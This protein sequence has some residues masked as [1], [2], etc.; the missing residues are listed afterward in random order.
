MKTGGIMA[1]GSTLQLGVAAGNFFLP[2]INVPAEN[3]ILCVL[4]VYF[5]MRILMD[6]SNNGCDHQWIVALVDCI[7]RE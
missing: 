4:V 3:I 1:Q 5:T 2:F 6:T 7:I